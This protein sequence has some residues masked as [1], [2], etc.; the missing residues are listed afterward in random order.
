VDYLRGDNYEW[1]FNS[2]DEWEGAQERGWEDWTTA[3]NDHNWL[4]SIVTT[5]QDL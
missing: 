5:D 1:V 3:L 2:L 4:T